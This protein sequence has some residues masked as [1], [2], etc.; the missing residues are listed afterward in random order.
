MKIFRVVAA[1]LGVVA[2]G[3]VI[4]WAMS[5]VGARDGGPL[6]EPSAIPSPS[7][8]RTTDPAVLAERKNALHAVVNSFVDTYF[9]SAGETQPWSPELLKLV[10]PAFAKQ[11]PSFMELPVQGV[12]RE[13]RVDESTA[14]GELSKDATKAHLEVRLIV[15]VAVQGEKTLQVIKIPRDFVIQLRYVGAGW[16]VTSID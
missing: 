8:E 1:F 14:I 5:S 2:L 6:K 12:I 16:R 7:V 11:S 3:V 10:S 9:V 13:V 4:V 15:G